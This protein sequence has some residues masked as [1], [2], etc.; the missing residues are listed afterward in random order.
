MRIIIAGPP[1]AG[2]VWLKCM[3]AS[4]YGLRQ[5]PLAAT[6][7]RP[8]LPLLKEWVEAGGFVDNA[9]FHQHY[10]YSPELMA[11]VDAVPAHTVTIIRDPYDAFVSAYNNIQAH[12]DTGLRSGRRTDQIMGKPLDDPEVLAFLR[13]GGFRNNMVRA[14]EWLESGRTQIV[15]YEELHADPVAALRRVTEALGPVPAGRIAAAVDACSAETMRKAGGARGGHVRTAKVG[16]AKE[17]LNEEHLAIFR[18]KHAELIRSLGYEV[19]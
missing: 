9:I 6:P 14:R 7:R 10:D 17:K 15:R 5:L 11:V 13:K 18:D 1:R 16:Q 19:R 4:I 12:E 8:Q 3:L 2:N